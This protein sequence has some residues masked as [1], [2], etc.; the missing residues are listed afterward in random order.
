MNC[1]NSFLL[2][3]FL[4][5]GLGCTPKSGEQMLKKEGLPVIQKVDDCPYKLYTCQGEISRKGTVFLKGNEIN[6]VKLIIEKSIYRGNPLK[7]NEVNLTKTINNIYPN[8]SQK[9]I[10][11]LDWE[12]KA[13]EILE[14]SDPD[15]AE[16]KTMLA[17]YIKALKIAKRLRP[18]IKWGYYGIPVQ[19]YWNRD[20]TWKNRSLKVL[21]PL[22]K[23]SDIIFPSVYDFYE[24][25][26]RSR[27]QDAEYVNDNVVLALEIGTRLNKPVMP[28]VWH[29][30]HN[31]NKKKGFS[32][33]PPDEFKSHV[34]AALK[35]N[36]QN[37]HVKAIVWW[38]ADRWFHDNGN[39]VLKREASKNNGFENYQSEVLVDYTQLIHELFEEN[40]R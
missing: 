37:K 18:N 23:E 36:F 32:L 24:D 31:S 28:F 38:G 25:G 26:V 11:A 7:V 39:K 35:A 10:C 21:L 22:F 20:D 17:E 16:F 2:I 8:K 3:V 12:G 19:N 29:R 40:C 34:D 14:K 13:L 6:E 33:I 30:Y 1:T 4:L 9:G 15:S 27:E 5:L